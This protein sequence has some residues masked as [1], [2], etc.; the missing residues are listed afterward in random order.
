M[1][2]FFVQFWRV[3]KSLFRVMH[4]SR[5]TNL[6]KFWILYKKSIFVKKK[7][8]VSVVLSADVRFFFILSCYPGWS[9]K[10]N[11]RRSALIQKLFSFDSLLSWPSSGS[12]FRVV[13]L[14]KMLGSRWGSLW[15]LSP[16]VPWFVLY[17]FRDISGAVPEWPWISRFMRKSSRRDNAPNMRFSV[18]LN[19]WDNFFVTFPSNSSETWVM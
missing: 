19:S 9:L 12:E 4:F 18:L 13:W 6:V 16:F 11:Q 7:L 2:C 17:V 10:A 3:W 5:E 15:K 8:N 1:I 14:W